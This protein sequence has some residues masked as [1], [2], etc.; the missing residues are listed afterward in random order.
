MLF[1]FL[2]FA[3]GQQSRKEVHFAILKTTS[4]IIVFLF[5]LPLIRLFFPPSSRARLAYTI[6]YE[7]VVS[8]SAGD[9]GGG[10]DRYHII[11][12]SHL[13]FWSDPRRYSITV[14]SMLAWA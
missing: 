14:Y 11:A 10:M 6:F 8:S 5:L 2:A 4:Y 3:I 1:L 13:I 7:V 12:P 9:L